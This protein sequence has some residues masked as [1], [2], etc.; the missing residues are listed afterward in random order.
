MSPPVLVAWQRWVCAALGVVGVGA[1]GTAVFV[2]DVEAGP[3][4]LLLAGAVFLI[5]G[6]TGRAPSRFK[7]GDNEVQWEGVEEF[8]EVA[9]ETRT[10]ENS[11]EL[12]AQLN[13]LSR[14][15]PGAAA[16]GLAVLAYEQLARGVLEAAVGSLN[17]RLADMGV[18][19]QLQVLDGTD[20]DFDLVLRSEAVSIYVEIKLRISED[21]AA[22]YALLRRLRN[23]GRLNDD[24]SDRRQELLLI[25]RE[26]MPRGNVAAF[27]LGV[28]DAARITHLIVSGPKDQGMVEQELERVAFD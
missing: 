19:K 14:L 12:V 23:A 10:P 24:D 5:I 26:P 21:H 20:S 7:M 15:S 2:T 16:P 13:E 25:T 18:A 6:V 27:R 1:G 8:V 9:V 11:P 4:A 17:R 3:V 22:Q 28:S